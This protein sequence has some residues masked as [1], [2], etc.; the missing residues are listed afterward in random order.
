MPTLV[1]GEY[2]LWESNSILRYL[3]TQYRAASPLYSADP[4]ARASIDRW[5]D[6]SLFT[7]QPAERPVFWSIIRTPEAE[8]ETAVLASDLEKLAPLWGMLDAQLKDRLFVEGDTFTIADIVLGA[9]AKRW[10]GLPGIQRQPMVNL[11]GWY[12][13]L[14]TRAAFQKYIDLELT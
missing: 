2:V 14:A 3:V 11:E 8:R 9:F 6:W 13:R 7:L 10:F 1:D 4:K 5:L 12:G